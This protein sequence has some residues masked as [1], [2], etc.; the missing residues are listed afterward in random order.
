MRRFPHICVYPLRIEAPTKG[1]PFSGCSNLH[2]ATW[3]FKR[4]TW[5]ADKT[6]CDAAFWPRI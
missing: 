1:F 5:I 2:G 6:A 3:Q 4:Q